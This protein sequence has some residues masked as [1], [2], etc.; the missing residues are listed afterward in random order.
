MASECVVLNANRN[1]DFTIV[2]GI[3]RAF[4]LNGFPIF[5][6]VAAVMP[7]AELQ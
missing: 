7:V 5:F 4:V 6:D 3:L 2:P 1:E